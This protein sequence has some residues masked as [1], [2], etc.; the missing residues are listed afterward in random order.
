MKIKSLSLVITVLFSTLILQ[1]CSKD[2][3]GGGGASWFNL[4]T[5]EDDKEMGAQLDAEIKSNPQDYPVLSETNYPT[6]YQYVRDIRDE[7][8]ATGK[9]EHKDDFDW[10]V[11]I[12][13]DDATLNAF[14][15]PGGYIYVYTG[16]I[17]YLESKD[18]LAGVMGHEIAHADLRHSTEQLTKQT[19]LSLIIDVLAGDN[20]G[21]ITQLAE[22]LI[23][24]KFSRSN[25]SQADEY[26]VIYLCPTDYNASGAAGFFEKIEAEGG[27]STPQFLSTHPNPENRVDDI[28]DKETEL[29]CTGTGTYDQDYA[30]FKNSLP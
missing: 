9:V 7:I 29:G 4:F 30:D 14:V 16:I 21:A 12:I 17:K 1:S 18:Q 22:G 3:D 26:S 20:Q 8:L 27:A 28:H 25:E 15:A 24:L 23:G 11:T 19:S 2:E 13:Q 6:V 5:I 10:P